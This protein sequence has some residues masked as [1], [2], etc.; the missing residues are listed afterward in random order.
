MKKILILSVSLVLAGTLFAQTNKMPDVPVLEG[1]KG[2]VGR[3]TKYNG[4]NFLSLTDKSGDNKRQS[5]GEYWE[6]SYVYDSA[7]RQKIKFGEFI[8]KQ[9]LDKGGALFFQDTTTIHFALPDS[10]MNLWGKV[11]LT[12]NT[13]YK[14]RLI[15]ERAFNNTVILDSEQ[16][17]VYEKI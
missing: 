4:F 7:F 12:S 3:I 13:I 15:R 1:Y 14:L 10:N 17:V 2:N 9:I 5:T 11:L 8:E 16:E 6:V